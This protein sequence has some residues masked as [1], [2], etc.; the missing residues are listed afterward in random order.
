MAQPTGGP[1]TTRY[2][3]AAAAIVLLGAAGAP[4]TADTAQVPAEI[5]IPSAVGNVA[6]QHRAHFKD[7]SIPCAECHHQIN[8]RK[9]DTPHPEYLKSSWINCTV[10]H[11]ES[12]KTKQQ[13]Y[14]C[15][16]CHRSNPA[17]IADETLSAKVV[18][19]RQ[20]WKCHQGGTGKDASAACRLCHAGRKNS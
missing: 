19:H 13:V 10:C 11:D 3:L 18:V 7:R 17:N 2:L 16:A 20:C 14:T 12:G 1:V 5:R 4:P 15:S 9:L 6:F 8:A